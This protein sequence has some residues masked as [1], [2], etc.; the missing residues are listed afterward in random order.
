MDLQKIIRTNIDA[1]PPGTTKTG[2][3]AVLSHIEAAYRH[4]ARGQ[5]SEEESAFT[6]AIYRTNQA[7]EGGVKEAYR[8]LTEKDPKNTTPFQIEKYLEEE[9]LFPERVL[10]QFTNYRMNWRNPSTHDYTLSFD[11]TEAFLAIVS[12]SAFVKLLIDQIT[13]QTAFEEARRDFASDTQHIE[14][15]DE[16]CLLD[17]V[18]SLFDE[19]VTSYWSKSSAQQIETEMQLIGAATGYLSSVAPDLKWTAGHVI[20]GETTHY[21][22]LLIEDKNDKVIVELKRG[23]NSALQAQGIQQLRSYLTA[24]SARNGLLFMFTNQ[25]RKYATLDASEPVLDMNLRIIRPNN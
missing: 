13:Q 9:E 14:P 23:K 5:S 7:F 15:I 3:E 16:N 8:T 2:L 18:A 6:D 22:D 20:R 1:L 10:S 24:A 21:I 19:F 4:L 11:E 17:R 12:V 25:A